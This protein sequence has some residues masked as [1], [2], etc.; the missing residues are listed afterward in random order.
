MKFLEYTGS[1]YRVLELAAQISFIN[2]FGKICE[3]EKEEKQL[4]N[5]G[6]LL[7]ITSDFVMKL[8]S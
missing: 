6:Y 5:G 2:K 3:G 4:E 1:F 7:Q 8:Q